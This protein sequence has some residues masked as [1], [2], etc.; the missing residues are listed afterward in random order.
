MGRLGLTIEAAE[1]SLQVVRRMVESF[2]SQQGV[3]APTWISDSPL[4]YF[5]LIIDG[6]PQDDPPRLPVID[7]SEES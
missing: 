1:R 2:A 5:R 4:S 6:S 3:L 7:E